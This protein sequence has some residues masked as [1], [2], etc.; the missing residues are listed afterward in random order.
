MKKNLLLAAALCLALALSACGQNPPAAGS[1]GS[2]AAVSS[3]AKSS[4]TPGDPASQPGRDDHTVLMM[5]VEGQSEEVPA[6]L[7]EGESYSIYIPDEGW[8]KTTGELPKGAVDQWVSAN[9]PEV[10]LTVCPDEAAGNW[11]ESQ[12]KAIVYEQKSEAGDVVF[13]A[14]TVY[15]AYPDEAAEGFGARL[16]VIAETFLV[17]E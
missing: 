12:Q 8:V 5:E 7:Y 17:T 1:S 9:N 3:G 13:R 10:T 11:V 15:M 4:E 2:S 16:P 14:W 6:T